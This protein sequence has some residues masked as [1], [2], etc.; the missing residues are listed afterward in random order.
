MQS[1]KPTEIRRLV[2]EHFSLQWCRDNIVVPL[3]IEYNQTTK[4][5]KLTIA[6]GNFTYL[7]TIGD[8]IKRR[9]ASSGKECQFVEKTP[10]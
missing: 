7:G 5:D 4:A 9:V 3:G 8:F 10:E 2:D 6:I 1:L